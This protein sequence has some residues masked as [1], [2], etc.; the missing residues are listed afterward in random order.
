M[1]V[2]TTLV[3]MR[4][5]VNHNAMREVFDSLVA[6]TD[7][8]LRTELIQRVQDEFANLLI[9]QIERTCWELKHKKQWNTGQIADT[10]NISER[11]VKMFIRWYSERT[12]EWNPLTRPR[13][14]EVIDISHLVKKQPPE[15][16]HQSSTEP[17]RNAAEQVPVPIHPTA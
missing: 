15:Q 9:E 1:V 12:G 10:L 5:Y 16:S 11:K 7:P 4:Y 13:A 17:T 3:P 14:A 2:G 8:H 6:E